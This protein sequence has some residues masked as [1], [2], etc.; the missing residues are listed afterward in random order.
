MNDFIP[1]EDFGM[2]LFKK[3][4]NPTSIISFIKSNRKKVIISS[5]IILVI[6]IGIIL[7]SFSNKSEPVA[8]TATAFVDRGNI[9]QII[10]GS[11]TIEAI[12]QYE[13]TSLVS[14]DILFDYFEEGDI[15][16]KDALMYQIDT[17]DLD[18]SIKKTNLSVEKAQLSYKN[19]V[20]AVND[21][22]IKADSK[23][24]ITNLYIK[25]GD[26]ISSGTKIADIVDN[27]TMTLTIDFLA[28]FAENITVGQTAN[29][30]LIGSF[31]TTNGVVSHVSTGSMPNQYGVSVTAVKIDVTNPGAI[32]QGDK[33]TATVGDY[34]CNAPGTF[35]Y[36]NSSVVTAEASGTVKTL[37]VAEDDIVFNG[38]VLAVLENSSVQDS[39]TQSRISLEDAKLS[40]EN[41]YDNLENYNIVAPISGKVIQ[42]NIKA[43]EKLDNSN[44]SSPMAI[45]SDLSSLVFTISID[46][47]DIS[48]I[49]VGQKVS[50]TADALEGQNF[51]GVVD[52]ISIVGTSSNGVTSYPVKVLIDN[53]EES[54][55]IPGMNV[56]ATIVV[57]SKENVLRVP[58]TAVNRGNTVTL[59][60]GTKAEVKIGLSDGTYVEIIE[61]LN[62]GDEII[63]P[64]VNVSSDFMTTMMGM[65]GGMPNAMQGGMPGGG[66]P[67]GGMPSG[68][69]SGGGMQGGGGRP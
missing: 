35:D 45:I 69:R 52:N 22:N 2:S 54:D 7:A 32:L 37:N 65:H 31:S 47:L 20:D 41:N 12:D 27:Q 51:T 56:D 39:L 9:T 48:Q 36:K 13:I 5:I 8:A 4:I 19:A 30:E 64:V 49:E 66:M 6:L 60:D 57:E 11:G 67:G 10:E 29:V 50:I 15:I 24:T 21:L 3:M 43:G 59:S 42:K 53:S 46:E 14:G 58:T 17:K 44:N 26:K 23:G 18:N 33:A 68:A 34:A 38:K 62:E 25:Q 1:K 28:A 40:L 16:E 61:G 63:V 55:L